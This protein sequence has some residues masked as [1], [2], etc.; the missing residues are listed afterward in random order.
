MADMYAGLFIV[1]TEQ[2]ININNKKWEYLEHIFLKQGNTYELSRYWA[3]PPSS[4]SDSIILMKKTNDKLEH[5]LGYFLLIRITPP[6]HSSPG[7]CRTNAM[8]LV[9]RV[10][11]AKAGLLR[12]SHTHT[13]PHIYIFYN[14]YI[15]IFTSKTMRDFLVRFRFPNLEI[16]A[17]EV[18]CMKTRAS[19]S[20]WIP[21]RR[22]N[23]TKR[24]RIHERT[25]NDGHA[26]DVVPSVAYALCVCAKIWR[27]FSFCQVGRI[28]RRS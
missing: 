21:L 6:T 25:D 18:N 20:Q 10:P 2:N 1:K 26:A 12:S 8:K 3:L 9:L 16:C 14:I 23:S 7:L 15:Y 5:F 11:K 28:L 24:Q 17:C 4:D 19:D 13:H 22:T 27:T